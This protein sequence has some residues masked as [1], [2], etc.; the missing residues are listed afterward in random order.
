MVDSILQQRAGEYA[1]QL[2]IA[3]DFSRALGSGMDGSVWQTNR[4][5]AVKALERQHNY[6]QELECYRRFKAAGV[7]RVG[8]FAVPELVGH[9]D[10]LQII[11][12]TIVARPFIL[13][14]A[15]VYLDRPPDYTPEVLA[16]DEERN[17]EIFEDRWQEVK[18]L[19][20]ALRQYGI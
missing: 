15:K 16:E 18:S 10:E 1:R 12:M 11:E 5:T 6:R 14:F 8:R 20:W 3:I 4:I 13:D 7:N 2:E 17:R 9:S 19:L